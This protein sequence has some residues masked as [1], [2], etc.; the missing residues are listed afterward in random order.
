[1]SRKGITSKMYVN[2][3]TYNSPTW[4][5]IDIVGDLAV[6]PN[7]QESDATIRRSRVQLADTTLLAIEVTGN[8]RSD[9]DDTGYQLL[10]DA[11]VAETV[12][13]IMCLN[14]ADDEDDSDGVRF[15][16]KIFNWS[17]DQARGNVL[18]KSF[19]IKPCPSTNVP[20]HVVVTAGAPVF[21]DFGEQ[22]G[23]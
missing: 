2:E 11:Y 13:D 5:H 22:A 6:N 7:W 16:G 18:Y 1:M 14:G 17:E 15:D 8:I 4:T 3:G 20:K 10:R 9:T 21:G 19:N 12:L 23:S